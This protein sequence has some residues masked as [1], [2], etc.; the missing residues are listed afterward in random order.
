V[1]RAAGLPPGSYIVAVLATSKSLPAGLGAELDDWEAN[2]QGFSP[3]WLTLRDSGATSVR[4]GEGTRVGDFV[5][6]RPGPPPLLAPDG[7]ALSYPTTFYPAARTAADAAVI[8]LE[9]GEARTAVDIPIAY[10]RM[11]R[12]SGVVT[13][14]DG[15]VGNL[16]LRLLPPDGSILVSDPVG[17]AS[18]VTDADSTFAFLAVSPGEYR[19]TT[20]LV[21]PR[22]Q[23]GDYATPRE[24]MLWASEP[25]TVGDTDVAD[26]V[27]ALKPGIRISGRVV[28][29]GSTGPALAEGQY[30]N[31]LLRPQGAG[32]WRG[33]WPEVQ[34]DGTFTIA[35]GAPPGRYQIMA[36]INCRRI[37]ACPTTWTWQT[38]TI[39]GGPV[40]Y[41]V[42]ELESAD[43]SG[44]E[45]TFSERTASVSGSIVD[46]TGA[47]HADADVIAFPAD[48][49]L[50]REDVLNRRVRYAYAMPSAAFGIDGLAPGD[51]YVVAVD[52]P[53]P[54]ED[55]G[56]LDRLIPGATRL[57]LREG[58]QATARLQVFRPQG[59]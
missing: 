53:Y 26:L 45:L 43:L 51:Y 57:T 6:A 15:P 1:Y 12:V 4:S 47:Q 44:L 13:A 35:A 27:I 34:P 54:Y 11:A 2:G 19:V 52:P 23:D 41:D 49:T 30:V 39:A 56:A 38:T 55:P 5:L 24:T 18:A 42:V 25:L 17:V 9:S 3:L 40:P 8:E 7:S 37:G 36:Q 31:V 50:W 58:E 22:P 16:M 32:S 46:A 20:A 21:P 10:S 33:S 48:T 59:R 29:T 14:P 28:F